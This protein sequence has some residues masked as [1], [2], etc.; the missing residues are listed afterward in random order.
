MGRVGGREGGGLAEADPRPC[1]PGLVASFP[2]VG[3]AGTR[4]DRQDRGRVEGQVDVRRAGPVSRRQVTKPVSRRVCTRR[5]FGNLDDGPPCARG[6]T[7]PPFGMSYRGRGPNHQRPS[8]G[9][10]GGR[11]RPGRLPSRRGGAPGWSIHRGD[12]RGPTPRSWRRGPRHGLTWRIPGVAAYRRRPPRNF[13]RAP[14][15]TAPRR[16][17]GPSPAAHYSYLQRVWAVPGGHQM[18]EA[19][20]APLA[21]HSWGP[22]RRAWCSPR[23]D[24][25]VRRA[26]TAIRVCD[27]EPRR[28]SGHR[29]LPRP[30]GWTRRPMGCGGLSSTSTARCRRSCSSGGRRQTGGKGSATRAG[31]RGPALGAARGVAVRR[32]ANAGVDTPGSGSPV[33]ARD[34]S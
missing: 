24:P 27:S 32:A 5:P 33:R 23:R 17:G 20:P 30:P 10:I 1:T 28:D 6:E 8:S 25:P 34:A 14:V 7:L 11:A 19:A 2:P 31:R 4:P 3:A 21:P 18:A 12:G 13:V 16:W 15:W 29:G 9:G 22:P 26:R